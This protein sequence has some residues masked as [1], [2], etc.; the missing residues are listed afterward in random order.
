[1]NKTN[2]KTIKLEKGAIYS[3][4]F[5]KINLQVYR[6]NDF[7]D[8]EAIMLIKNNK[9]VVIES[10]CFYDNIVELETYIKSLNVSVEGLVLAYHMG[11]GK[12]LTNV[13][14][15]A[16]NKANK[17]GT[18]GGGKS[19]VNNFTKVFG[20]IFDSSIHQVTNLV[21]GDRLNIADIE[22]DLVETNDAFDVIIPEINVIYTHMLGHDCHSIIAGF[23]G[24][25]EMIDYLE[26]FVKNGYE[27]VLTSHYDPED[28]NDVKTKIEYIKNI[29][30]LAK[31]YDNAELFKEAVKK[32]YP[33]YSG[34]NYLDI[35]AS[36]FFSK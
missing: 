18:I 31:R 25:N 34:L 21:P 36:T 33:N 1:M 28:L 30:T 3:Y 29:K 24:A 23:V 9:M 22:L 12:F 2:C 26:K 13:K 8:D 7:I 17:F 32:E 6:T 15:Y 16:T 14:K 4:S 11:G 19:L 20:N 35:T 10:P 27:L 5:D